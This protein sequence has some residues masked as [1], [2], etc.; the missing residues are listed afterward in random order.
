MSASA[1]CILSFT[2]SGPTI[3]TVLPRPNT[4]PKNWDD[5]QDAFVLYA[6]QHFS[7]RAAVETRV[8]KQ[9]FERHCCS[10]FTAF[11]INGA[12]SITT[13]R[14]LTNR[15]MCISSRSNESI[16]GKTTASVLTWTEKRR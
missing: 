14:F 5:L 7:K 6:R 8:S 16:K 9:K 15:F 1:C 3:L 11:T 10:R 13:T 2:L 4:H 12:A